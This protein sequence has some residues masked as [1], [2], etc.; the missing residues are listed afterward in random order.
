[1]MRF[2]RGDSSALRDIY[3]LYKDE[4]VSLTGALLHDKTAAED[5]YLHGKIKSC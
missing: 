3:N 1:M 5:A 4:L 2:N